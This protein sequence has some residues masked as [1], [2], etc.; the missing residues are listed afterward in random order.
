M[1][2]YHYKNRKHGEQIHPEDLK[3]GQRYF[4]EG[5]FLFPFEAS[6]SQVDFPD[7]DPEI[8]NGKGIGKFIKF[9][10]T[11]EYISGVEPIPPIQL[12][13]FKKEKLVLHK[14]RGE[15]ERLVRDQ[16]DL[17][18]RY[19]YTS[20]MVDELRNRYNYYSPDIF[21]VVIDGS[22]FLKPPD[23]LTEMVIDKIKNREI[24][25]KKKSPEN[26]KPVSHKKKGGKNRKNKSR[27]MKKTISK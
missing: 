11:D 9:W 20:D 5:G 18:Y 17:F 24:T 10:T 14:K 25:A 19:Y 26:V 15:N 1:T 4:I 7:P 23:M 2:S 12:A 21:N 3:V 8:Y 16:I 6:R 27:K 13:M 22:Y